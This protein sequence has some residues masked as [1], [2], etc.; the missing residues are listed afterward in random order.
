[1]ERTSVSFE[2]GVFFTKPL[3]GTIKGIVPAY[4]ANII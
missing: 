2:P 4:A 1:M 3:T